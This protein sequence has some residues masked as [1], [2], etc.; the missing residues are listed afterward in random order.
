MDV[1]ESLEETASIIRIALPL[2]TKHDIAITP[3]NYTTWYYYVSGKN[4]ELQEAIDSI[5]EDK[6]PFSEKTNEML[7]QRF[8][9]NKYENTLNE[10]R[11]NLQETLFVIAGELTEISGQTEKY[12]STA[13]KSVDKLT[14]NMSVQDIKAVL[15]EVIDATK[16]I[17]AS[18]EMT[19]QRLKDTT[20][21]MKVLQGEFKKAKTE[22]LI[23]FL[24]GVLNRKGFDET[25]ASIIREAS[26][27]FCLLM[28][29]IDH[30]KKF[31]DVHG[32]VVGDEVLKFVAKNIQKVMRG[33][34]YIARF[35]GEEFTVILPKTLLL[36]A[37][38]VAE[39]IRD[40]IAK[41]KLERKAKSELLG[42]I[43]VS[44]GVAQYRQGEPTETFINRADQALYFAK[45]AGRNR[46]ATESEI[47]IQAS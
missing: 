43:T 40:S 39:N 17:R 34:D 7:Y 28:I 22:L 26:D 15:N 29:D 16:E 11:E 5:I 27:I 46:V 44:I 37:M 33:N 38:T 14:E 42:K 2:M 32:H 8:F 31:N 4:N 36:G 41:L 21:T 20:E 47:A 6:E 1:T 35:G 23:D 3:K 9:V 30:F 10:I 18:S 19:K 24:T 45:D 13:L 25:L 12:E